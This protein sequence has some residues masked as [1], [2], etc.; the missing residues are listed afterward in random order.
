MI[1]VSVKTFAECKALLAEGYQ[2][3]S[4]SYWVSTPDSVTYN[5]SKA[6]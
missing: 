5:L 3:D 6:S 4:V 1:E 2:L